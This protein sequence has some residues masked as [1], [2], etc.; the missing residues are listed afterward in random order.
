MNF[1]RTG[2]QA[3]FYLLLQHR[4]T[5]L[6]ARWNMRRLPTKT[7]H[8]LDNGRTTGRRRR[9]NVYFDLS[10]CI[11]LYW[12]VVVVADSLLLCCCRLY[13]WWWWWCRCC[14]CHYRALLL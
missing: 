14:Y 8:M 7:V 10:V 1:Q 6:H 11:G 12:F 5:Y 3:V 9:M 2:D 4:V 13:W